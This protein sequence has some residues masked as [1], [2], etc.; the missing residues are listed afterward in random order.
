LGLWY[1]E[2]SCCSCAGFG[3]IGTAGINGI[4]AVAAASTA[5]W[6]VAPEQLGLMVKLLLLLRLRVSRL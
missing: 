2:C 6:F 5:A 4:K 1:Q 3:G